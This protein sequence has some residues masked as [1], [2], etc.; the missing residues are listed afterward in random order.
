MGK[1]YGRMHYVEGMRR[2]ASEL[3]SWMVGDNAEEIAQALSVIRK[4]EHNSE[5][6]TERPKIRSNG[7][8]LLK[9][10]QLEPDIIDE[11][12]ARGWKI[13]DAVNNALALVYLKQLR[14]SSRASRRA[15]PQNK[16]TKNGR[17]VTRISIDEDLYEYLNEHAMRASRDYEVQPYR[18]SLMNSA[19]RIY[20][21][22]DGFLSE[23]AQSSWRSE[24]P[25]SPDNSSP[26]GVSAK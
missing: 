17:V 14:D 10:V 19:L 12:R 13:S 24:R 15:S 21:W 8:A 20:L 22:I 3:A 18:T 5:I 2:A 11:V 26:V 25:K 16:P 6:H 23:H 7:R 9:K 4:S 1:F